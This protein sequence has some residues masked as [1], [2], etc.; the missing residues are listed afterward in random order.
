MQSFRFVNKFIAFSGAL[1]LI[2]VGLTA[3]GETASKAEYPDKVRDQTYSS[4]SLAS[5]TGGIEILGEADSRKENTG[6]TVN[7][8]LWRAS[9]DTVSFMPIASADP[10]GGV[11]TTDW[12]SAPDQPDERMKLNVFVLDREL[13]ADGVR[14]RA[15]KQVKDGTDWRDA[16]VNGSV[17]ATLEETILTRARQMR[18][19]QKER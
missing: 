2:I 9:L 18:L 16:E 7:A 3:C 19:A 10:F 6:I 5:E 12:Y 13:R 17:A 14:V 11:I 1:C 15:F 4:G 8:F